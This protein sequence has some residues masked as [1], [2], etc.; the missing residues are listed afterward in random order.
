VKAAM[1]TQSAPTCRLH[2]YIE[3]RCSRSDE[4]ASVSSKKCSRSKCARSQLHRKS[5]QFC[6]RFESPYGFTVGSKTLGY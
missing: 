4:K 6:L 1:F 3:R 5:V 2:V